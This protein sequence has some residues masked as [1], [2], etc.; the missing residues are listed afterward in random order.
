MLPPTF[1]LSIVI[2]IKTCQI[3][4]SKN[5][6]QHCL[7]LDE[8]VQLINASQLQIGFL[9]S[10]VHCDDF[11][12]LSWQQAKDFYRQLMTRHFYLAS[13][14]SHSLQVARTWFT[15]ASAIPTSSCLSDDGLSLSPHQYQEQMI[16]NQYLFDL[17]QS[18]IIVLFK[19]FPNF[20]C[21][22][23]LISLSCFIEGSGSVSL[24]LFCGYG[25][26]MHWMEDWKCPLGNLGMKY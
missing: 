17:F 23:V 13:L 25:S 20:Y 21:V 3:L 19:S 7:I 22:L 2:N 26:G 9:K 10:K 6:T 18:L 15:S 4:M 8:L 24:S 5:N 12:S 11:G 14:F 16:H 1:Y